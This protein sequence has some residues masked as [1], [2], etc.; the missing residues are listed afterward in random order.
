MS[1]RSTHS[2]E[3]TVWS[4]SK[5][6]KVYLKLNNWSV[7]GVNRLMETEH[8]FEKQQRRGEVGLVRDDSFYKSV[9]LTY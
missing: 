3:A 8:W 9:A 5:G 1:G 6:P 4:K 2:V 7:L